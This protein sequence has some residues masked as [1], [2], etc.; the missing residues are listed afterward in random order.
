MGE[1]RGVPSRFDRIPALFPCS[2]VTEAF[3]IVRV[4]VCPFSTWWMCLSNCSM[5]MWCV[6]V[7][8]HL[9]S[10]MTDLQIKFPLPSALL[11]DITFPV[12]IRLRTLVH[13]ET[14]SNRPTRK[15]HVRRSL[16]VE[17]YSNPHNVTSQ[18]SWEELSFRTGV[19]C[20]YKR[21]HAWDRFIAE[22]VT[23]HERQSF[24]SFRCSSKSHGLW[25]GVVSCVAGYRHLLNCP[26]HVTPPQHLLGII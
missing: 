5:F 13:P 2:V 16:S 3:W 20:R 25:M 10:R 19:W 4:C 8:V 9:S 17:P 12:Y 18:G 1:A 15:C 24:G 7:S 11:T 6:C 21:Y 26:R 23:T 22:A 14:V